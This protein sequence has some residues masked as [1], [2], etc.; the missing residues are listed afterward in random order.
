MNEIE[1][2]FNPNNTRIEIEVEEVMESVSGGTKDYEKLENKPS[3]NS[4]ELVGNKTF[5]ELGI[6]PL[7]NIEIMN[8]I[9]RASNPTSM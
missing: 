3:I 6:T 1:M 7:S 5:E 8:I 9:N 2:R 4:V